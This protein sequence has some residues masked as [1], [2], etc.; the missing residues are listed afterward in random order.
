MGYKN[1]LLQKNRIMKETIYQF[2]KSIPQGKVISY[3]TM[4]EY[5]GTSARAIGQIMKNNKE[6]DKF[7]CY[8]VVKSDGKLG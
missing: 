4:A 8:K 7:S 5:F 3:K 1:I 2:L 6:A